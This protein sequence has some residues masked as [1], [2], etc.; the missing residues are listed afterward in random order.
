MRIGASLFLI[1]VGQPGKIN[2]S[3]SRIILQ[4]SCQRARVLAM[5]IHSHSE[6]L[7][8]AQNLVRLPR[9]QHAA[10]EFHHSNQCRLVNLVARDRDSAHRIR[11]SAQKF[12]GAM[13]D[14]ICPMLERLAKIR[15]SERVIDNQPSADFVSDVGASVDVAHLQQRIRNRFWFRTRRWRLRRERRPYRT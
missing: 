12:R 1:A 9:A 6:C 13:N 15:R 7:H 10:G 14:Q 5:P 8:A 4:L 11:M 2:S 3:D